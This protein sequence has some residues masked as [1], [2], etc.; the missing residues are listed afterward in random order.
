MCIRDSTNLGSVPYFFHA[1]FAGAFKPEAV[2]SGVLGTA[3]LLYTSRAKGVQF[4]RRLVDRVDY[5]LVL[6]I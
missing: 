1:V 6:K 5:S 4:L 3:C 2:F